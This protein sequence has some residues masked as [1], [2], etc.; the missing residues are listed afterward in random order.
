MYKSLV[1]LFATLLLLLAGCKTNPPTTPQIPAQEYGKISITSNT[2]SA[3]IFIDNVSNGEI[4]PALITTTVGN[5]LV[6]LEKD[7]YIPE[8]KNVVVEK[9]STLSVSFTLK[10][11][12]ANKIVLIEDFA[13]VS[14]NPCVI[15]NKILESIKSSYGT[16]K[17]VMIKYPTNFPSPNDPF[18][19][20]NQADC[21]VRM[22]F[23]NILIAPTTK[24]DGILT[25]TSTDSL[26]VKSK[27]DERIIQTS[28]I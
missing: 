3:L 25:P 10:L 22:S 26:S 1:I 14:C 5:H 2:D 11:A 15:S 8:S 4:T 27:I 24:V 23:Y 19:L 21:N 6:R 28:K 9:D 18:Y 16:N 12:L 7:N 13:N 20:A 17:V